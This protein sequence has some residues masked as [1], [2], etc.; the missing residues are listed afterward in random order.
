MGPNPV[1]LV[2][3]EEETI[4]TQTQTQRGMTAQGHSE[5]VATPRPGKRLQK[6]PDLPTT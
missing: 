5:K 1:W 2:S 4:R 3:T 6:K